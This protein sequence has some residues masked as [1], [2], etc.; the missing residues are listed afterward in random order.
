MTTRRVLACIAPRETSEL[1]V[2]HPCSS[3]GGT[4]VEDGAAG[5]G[6]GEVVAAL[7]S[8]AKAGGAACSDLAGGGEEGRARDEGVG[9][10]CRDGDESQGTEVEHDDEDWCLQT[11]PLACMSAAADVWMLLFLLFII[12]IN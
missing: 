11:M 10:G 8:H 9:T 1:T 12:I 4:G 5:D 7:R 6:D 3:G 2:S